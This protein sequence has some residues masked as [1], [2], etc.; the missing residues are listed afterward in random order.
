ML[1]PAYQGVDDA[2]LAAAWV[3][4]RRFLAGG[5]MDREEGEDPTIYVVVVN[6]E[7]QYSIWPE[8]KQIPKGWRPAGRSGSKEECLTWVKEVWTDM[9]PLSLRGAKSGEVTK[10]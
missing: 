4:T 3:S 1:S 10:S 6:H 2:L 7:E 9:T 8:W 5:R